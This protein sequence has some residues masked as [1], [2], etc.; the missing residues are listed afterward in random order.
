MKTIKYSLF[1]LLLISILSPAFVNQVT[2]KHSFLVQPDDK[3]ISSSSLDQAVQIISKRLHDYSSGTSTV[4]VVP[5]E[6]R[7]KISFDDSLNIGD[8]EKLAT[9]KGEIEFREAVSQDQLKSTPPIIKGSEIES[10]TSSRDRIKIRLKP[11][12]AGVFAEATK[13][14]MNNLIAIVLDGKILA[15]PRVRSEIPSGEI[16][17]SGRYTRAEAGYISAMLGNGMLP[18]TFS[19]VK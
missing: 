1:L 4:T 17:V 9:H 8:V 18:A 13:R 14:N 5:G 3:N 6:K 15:A 10:A 7:I 19:I 12:A 16:E 2:H 11:A